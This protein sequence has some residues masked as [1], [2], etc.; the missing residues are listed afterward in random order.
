MNVRFGRWLLPVCLG[1]V[2]AVWGG[3]SS[4]PSACPGRSGKSAWV[5]AVGRG[6]GAAGF[7]VGFPVEWDWLRQDFGNEGARRV[8][9]GDFRALGRE[10]LGT[11]IGGLKPGDETIREELERMVRAEVADGDVRWLPLYARAAESR[12]AQRLGGLAKSSTRI[13]FVKRRTI[14][15]SFFAY[16][17]GQSDAQAERH[18]LP[19]S[20]LC[21]M[22]FDGTRAVVS[23]LLEDKSGVIRDPAVSWDGGRIAF[24]WK[25]SLNGDDYHIHELDLSN[26]RIR[27]VTH[28]AGV[29]DYEPAY[30]PNGDFVFSSTRCVQTV[31]CW[32][33]EVSNL[34]ACGPD[35]QQMRRL[36]FD[37]VHTVYPQVLEDGRVI[38]T[39]WDYNDRGQVFPQPLFQMNPD[40]TGQAEFYGN[41]SWFPTTIAHA[42]GIPGGS[43]VL[44]ILCGHH[45]SQAG[46]LAVIDPSLGRQ[47]NEGVQLVSPVRET[48]AVR[49]D[50]YGQEGELFAYPYPLDD[51]EWLVS[52]APD[53]W[54]GKDRRRSDAD[55][56]IY[57]MDIDGRRELLVA[58]DGLPCVQ[59]VVVGVRPRPP[60]RPSVVDYRKDSGTYYVQDVHEG[61]GLAGVPRG[62]IRRMRVVALDF[63]PAGIRSN[64]SSGPAGGALI[65]TPVS[66]GNGAW[67][68]KTVLGETVV[69]EDGSAFFTVPARTPVYFQMLDADGRAVQTMRS[70]STLQPGE[71]AS[72]VGCH[73]TKNSAPPTRGYGTALATKRPPL[74]LE[75]FSDST[76]GFSFAR[77]IQPILDRHCTSCHNHREPVLELARGAGK[78]VLEMAVE[79]RSRGKDQAF[80]LLGEPVPDEKAGRAWSDAYLVLTQARRD[81]TDGPFRGN[82]EGRMVRWISSQSVPTPL[83]PDSSGSRRS[84]LLD[85]VKADHHGVRLSREEYGKIACWIDLLVP[86]CG[87]YTE[88]NLWNAA[89]MTKYRRFEEKRKRMEAMEREAIGVLAE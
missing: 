74:D 3:Q 14:R 73:E 1:A 36:G 82:P 85:L 59:P 48:P 22:T 27:Q 42:R 17:E 39:R 34:Y 80:S 81:G 53:G 2:S 12:R 78:P 6:E 24:A 55:F 40:G 38:Y 66:I 37:Q 52:Y 26:H 45:S 89:E 47:E 16:T 68:V 69:Y 71:S 87:D 62:M 79:L 28:G 23:R 51:R 70:W 29:A 44:A 5:D 76:S 13:A 65:S 54:S 83:A 10:A 67:D 8:T 35:G 30:L 43:K 86:F 60:V 32:W 46:K 63:R 88:A 21:L 9:E 77:E 72:C 31:D 33:T 4:S 64:H 50:A 84:P 15:P 41:S 20:E 11:L 19:G 25:K 49:V 61:P 18:F 75:P 58:D 56:G 57:W 7:A